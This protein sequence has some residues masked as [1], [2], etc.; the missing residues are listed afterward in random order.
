MISLYE[1]I[2]KGT[3]D[4]KLRKLL[5][6]ATDGVNRVTDVHHGALEA[7]FHEHRTGHFSLLLRAVQTVADVLSLTRK[8]YHI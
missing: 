1:P 4:G 8:N 6:F 5:V 7:H 3:S 2:E